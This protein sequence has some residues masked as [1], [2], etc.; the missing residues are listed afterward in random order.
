MGYHKI[1]APAS[2]SYLQRAMAISLLAKG[3][4]ILQNI[5]W[6]N[7][8]LA[9][10]KLIMELGAKI[11]EK[12][13]QLL[14]TAS[15]LQVNS[16]VYSVE[17]SGLALRMFCPII[18]LAGKKVTFSVHGSL[19]NRPVTFIAQA[20]R[21]LGV[22]VVTGTGFSPISINGEITA[23]KI[24]I[25]GSVSSQLLSGLLIALPLVNGDSEIT[26]TTLK[27]IP[28]ID[29]TIEIIRHF[30]VQVKHKNYKKFFIKGNQSYLPT[31]FTIEGDWSGASFFLVAGALTGEVEVMN[32]SENSL[33]ADRNI[34]KALRKS[35]AEV[36]TFPNSVMVRKKELVAFD[37]DATHCPDLFPPL[38]VLAA[39]CKGT[40]IIKG[41][42][43]L[44]HKESNRMEV[45]NSELSKAGIKVEIDND[46]MKITGGKITDC[47]I[48][49]NNDHRI[50]MMGGVLNLITNGMVNV[51]NKEVVNKS[52]PQFFDDIKTL[53][54]YR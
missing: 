2:K 20:L 37:F 44:I 43:R 26:V 16:D 7:D 45:L 24:T 21:Q 54:L 34:L 40:S 17:E 33:Q 50:A 5:S 53:T 11:V 29:M 46:S 39:N 12:N 31:E 25:D 27:S 32:I 23:G 28:Y 41:V 1:F 8:T 38:A 6:C 9:V 19:T 3:K 14:I 48:D 35:G 18:A 30:G 13:R 51:S 42:S 15:S 36:I 52:Y 4:T 22:N 49:S 47:I 10:K